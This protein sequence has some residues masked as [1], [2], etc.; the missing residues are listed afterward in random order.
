MPADQ[1]IIVLVVLLGIAMFMTGVSRKI[2]LPYTILLVIVGIILGRVA[3]TWPPL[4]ILTNFRL[5]PE[6]MLFV[7]LPALIFESGYSIDTRQLHQD[8]PPILVLAIPGMLMSTFIVGLGVWWLL[9]IKLIVALVFGALISATD[10]VA[11]VALFKELGAP[12]RLNVLVEGE[13]LLNDATAIV[14][15]SILLGI[16]VAGGGI[17]WG[18]S[19]GIIFEFLRVFIGGVIVGSLLGFAV[20]EVLHRMHSDLPVILTTSIVVA[21]ASFVLSEHVLHV[22]GVMSVVGSA[23]ALKRFSILRF[24]Q[25]ATHAIHSSWEVIV[26]SLNSLLF[27]LVGMSVKF[28]NVPAMI[29][30]TLL[31]VILILGARYISVYNLLPIATRI[32]HLP[33]VSK[34]DK[35]IMWW[36][37]LKGGLAIAVVLSIPDSLPEKQFLFDLTIGV[38][39]F[40]LLVSAPTIRPLMERLGLNRLSEGEDLELRNALITARK[41]S[42]SWLT[43]LLNHS[44]LSQKALEELTIR[45]RLAF[46]IGMFD[47]GSEKHEDDEYMAIFRAYQTEQ[48]VLETL[49]EAKVISQYVYLRMNDART[50]M[51]EALRLGKTEHRALRESNRKS[52]FVRA[53]GYL[54]RYARERTWL[55]NLLSRYQLIRLVQQIERHIAK[56]IIS[57]NIVAM[58]KQQEDLDQ[59]VCEKLIENYSARTQFYRRELAHA[60]RQFSGFYSRLMEQTAHRSMI[61]RGWRYVDK[62]FGHGDIGSKGYNIIKRK[63]ELELESIS[64][65]R[66]VRAP[67]SSESITDLLEQVNLF[68]TLSGEDRQDLENQATEIT[69]L[70]GDTI[71]G[72]TERGDNFYILIRGTA[73]VLKQDE[74]GSH[75]QVTEFHDGEIIGESSLLEDDK[76]RHRRSATI[77]ARTACN[78]VCINRKA[79]LDIVEKYPDIRRQL[80]TIHDHRLSTFDNNNSQNEK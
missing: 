59:S 68:D 41:D 1:V 14:A 13:S 31:V 43:D 52:L 54:L 77:V 48:A 18:D 9:D 40:T 3:E 8:L 34:A 72:E 12:K 36:G 49:Y 29:G 5:G 60:E 73:A 21:Y 45:T 22:S 69:F 44:L 80:Q 63:I 70:T 37:G 53:E 20:C 50:S 57:N 71:V 74:D 11:V 30:A 10:P 35:H 78:M 25:D 61:N 19:G 66:A 15:F 2:H 79:M 17:D 42:S 38:V 67:E 51:R 16:A 33:H 27:L 39:M 62:Q 26:L 75:Q 64:T 4:A 24:G 32:F 23:I 28:E 47:E 65:F 6:V 58:L 7:F 76:G 55:A 46:S 56:V